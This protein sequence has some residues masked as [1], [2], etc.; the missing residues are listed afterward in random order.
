MG[1]GARITQSIKHM[2][3]LESDPNYREQHKKNQKNI[4]EK[5]KKRLNRKCADCKTIL[6]P[7]T[8][9]EFCR[10]CFMKKLWEKR[11]EK[12]GGTFGFVKFRE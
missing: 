9:G 1:S 12:G 10:S 2:E 8:K 4:Y 11:R 3:R 6:A 5:Q 7:R